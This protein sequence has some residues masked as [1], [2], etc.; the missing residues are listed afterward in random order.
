MFRGEAPIYRCM[1][2]DVYTGIRLKLDALWEE[3]YEQR[4]TLPRPANQ[5]RE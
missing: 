1:P 2:M 5:N 3:I 4:P